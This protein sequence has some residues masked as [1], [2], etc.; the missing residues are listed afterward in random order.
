M[1]EKLLN[2][3]VF[4][5]EIIVSAGLVVV[6]ALLVVTFGMQLLESVTGGFEFGRQQFT[7][8]IST[9]LE[10]FIVIELFRIALA[11]MKHDNVVPTVLEA[12][13]VAVAR[14]FVV[15]EPKG[16]YM[17]TA[18]GLAALLLAIAVAWWLLNRAEVLDAD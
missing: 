1:I 7:T 17:Q 9:A 8:V 11:Y 12:A 15:F 18:F 5:L 14:K 6:A 16:D 4:A 13:L 3:F 10:V 2:R